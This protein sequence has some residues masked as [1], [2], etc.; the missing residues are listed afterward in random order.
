MAYPKNKKRKKNQHEP[1]DGCER[2]ANKAQRKPI[3]L[4]TPVSSDFCFLLLL[5][6]CRFPWSYQTIKINRAATVL[7]RCVSLSFTP[8]LK[9]WSCKYKN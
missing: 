3:F 4:S 8:F 2:K 5:S 6:N 7:D 1:E 9:S